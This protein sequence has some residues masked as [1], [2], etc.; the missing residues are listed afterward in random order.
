MTVRET[1]TFLYKTSRP[2]FWS[3]TFGT[4][5]VGYFLGIK[6][7]DPKEL[8][9]WR[10]L[11]CLVFFTFVANLFVY[12]VNDLADED[13][14][15]HNIK[16]RKQENLLVESQRGILRYSVFAS[17]ILSVL[18]AIFIPNVRY[19]LIGFV[20]LGACYSLPPFRFKMRPFIDSISNI[21]YLFPALIGYLLN[22][23]SLPS[24]WSWWY[25]FLFPI[26]MHLYSAIPDIDADKKASLKTTAVL[27]GKDFSL[28]IC[29]ILWLIFA[30]MII[31]T[32]NFFPWSLTLLIYPTLPLLNLNI[33]NFKIEKSYWFFP[34]INFVIGFGFSMILV[35][36][37]YGLLP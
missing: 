32:G 11:V 28:V 33:K 22:Q 26:A 16:K 8:L 5:I 20:I 30:L 12:G 7:A 14:D 18:I 1:A 19:W 35:A 31:R 36:K 23:A 3:Y 37:L 25:I 15:K 17:I 6:V 21:F 9:D 13:T 29:N 34:Y 2:K 10:F 4:F 24:F 27:F